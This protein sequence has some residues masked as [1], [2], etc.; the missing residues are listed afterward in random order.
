MSRAA[1]GS[2]KA[3]ETGVRDQSRSLSNSRTAGPSSSGVSRNLRSAR[4]AEANPQ[5]DKAKPQPEDLKRSRVEE[6]TARPSREQAASSA[7]RRPAGCTRAATQGKPAETRSRSA[8]ESRSRSA[9]ETS[10]RAAV[11]DAKVEIRSRPTRLQAARPATNRSKSKEQEKGEL[12]RPTVQ[13]RMGTPARPAMSS[14]SGRKRGQLG[15]K[16]VHFVE[17]VEQDTVEADKMSRPTTNLLEV[18]TS[19]ITLRGQSFAPDEIQF[20]APENIE[21]FSF[22]PLSPGSAD[23]FFQEIKRYVSVFQ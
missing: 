19:K 1:A 3:A 18:W 16:S 10:S 9:A 12:S 15:K 6:K 20:T 5:P 22:K 4:L 13:A 7:G 21:G 8:A 2:T 14:E 17:P 11:S 23:H